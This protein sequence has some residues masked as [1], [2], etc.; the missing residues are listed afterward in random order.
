[1]RSSWC[2]GRRHLC[3]G[4]DAVSPGRSVQKTTEILLLQFIDTVL[5]VCCAG[6]ASSRVQSV[7]GQ[8]SSH[9]CSP[10]S[11]DTVVQMT[12]VVQRQMLGGT[13]QQHTTHNNTAT[14]GVYPS[15]PFLFVSPFTMDLSWAAAP[16]RFSLLFPSPVSGAFIRHLFLP[17]GIP[18]EKEGEKEERK[19]NLELESLQIFVRTLSGRTLVC[20]VPGDQTVEG[21][22]CTIEKECP[23]SDGDWYLTFN[24]KILRHGTLCSAGVTSDSYIAMNGRLRGGMSNAVPGAWYCPNCQLGG[25]WPARRNCFRCGQPRPANDVVPIDALP[26]RRKKGHFREE[27]Y[28]NRQPQVVQSTC[29]TARRQPQPPGPVNAPV[30]TSNAPVP[31]G[32]VVLPP[33]NAEAMLSWLQQL[34]LDGAVLEMVR[35]KLPPPKGP[36]PG[37]L[38]R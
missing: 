18:V 20:R 19:E 32:E 5:D 16:F 38:R 37:S 9:S 10:F 17:S 27:Q 22:R 1:M 23:Y 29:P 36:R 3:R 7:R 13:I 35:A 25:C 30:N 4:A 33:L 11:M 6:P 21:L 26:R 14:T 2:Q 8:P 24:C 12:V 31:P 28:L 34:G 15:V